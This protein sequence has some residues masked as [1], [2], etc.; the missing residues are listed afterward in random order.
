MRSGLNGN[1]MQISLIR[2]IS[3]AGI[4]IFASVLANAVPASAAYIESSLV[5]NGVFLN[6]RSMS[7]TQ[8]QTFL[9][10]KKSYLAT[11]QTFSGRDNATVPASQIIYEA[12]VDYGINPQVILA[13]LQ[14]EQSLVTDPQPASS[15]LT[16]AMGY[17]C[18][19][20]GSCS[21]PGFYKQVDNG[22]WQLRLNFERANGNNSW[23]NANI[24]YACANASRYYST[25]LY[26]NRSV[27][28]IDDGG[29][30]YKT[31]TI[32]N[33]ATASL[34]CY[35]PHA[36][37][38][39]SS[40]YYSGSYNFTAS[41]DS[42]GWSL[43][44]QAYSAQFVSQSAFPQLDPGQTTT[45]YFQYK[46][47][48]G[49]AWYDDS[50]IATSPIG[51]GAYPIHLATSR[52]L[53]RSSKFYGIG[54]ANA[55]RPAV[56]FAAVYEADGVTLASNQH[57]A[58][59]GQIVKFS[60]SMTAPS[61]LAPGTYQEN[62]MPVAEG[63]PNGAFND[64]GTYLDV[65]VNRKPSLSWMSQS[66]FPTVNASRSSKAYL[67]LTNNGNVDLYDDTSIP[68][69]PAGNY[70]VHLATS[71]PINS[72]SDFGASWPSSNRPALNFTAVLNSD[73]SPAS[74]QHVV[75]PHQRIR[76]EFDLTVP[77]GYTAAT[78]RQCFQPVLEGAV[79][80][81]FPNLGIYLDV[82]V[83]ANPVIAY[84]SPIPRRDITSGEPLTISFSIKNN[85][86][87][88]IPTG[89]KLKTDASQFQ[90]KSWMNNTTILT[91]PTDIA[92]GATQAFNVTLLAPIL[93]DIT[94]L[95]PA[96][97]F[98]TPAD[99]PIDGSSSTMEIKVWPQIFS[100]AYSGQSPYPTLSYTDT[101]NSFFKY[102]NVGNKPWYDDT[103]LAYAASRDP[104]PVHLATSVPINRGSGFALNWP[105]SN[106]P[107]L[108]F[109]AVYESDGQTLATDQHIVRPGQI[110]QFSF[111]QRPQSWVQAGI[112]REYFQPVLE[113]T[114]DGTFNTVG[115]YLDVQVR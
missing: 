89:S 7:Q 75:R 6:S 83:S 98:T 11:Y 54:W 1:V 56:N 53:N 47:T 43:R 15:Q 39:S 46:N 18:P 36:Y 105:T 103:S 28:F 114:V 45:V 29:V 48:G 16:Y 99:Q 55:A 60:F 20:G 79:S 51:S 108:T 37:P 81:Y 8:I 66:A 71:C 59:P 74:N 94:T 113:G 67:E 49:V 24:T 93:P 40:Y 90:D 96:F 95:R 101:D 62:F 82:T 115:T 109:T 65:T 31:F 104:L 92:A 14:K 13:T 91:T 86:N 73:G 22:T 4:A 64:P 21:Y 63:T 52:P 2:V 17:G 41:F 30:T 58:L 19:D 76:Y 111:Q 106:R 70:P 85:G 88:V 10:G 12:A 35:T 57:V 32:L 102:K 68:T 69:A 34:Y 100:A 42:W 78:Y 61:D 97:S 110:A 26:P 3:Y 112:Y 5:D 72:A 33:T 87:A 77:A 44:D 107:N 38:G 9:E 25:G 84:G 50:S 80:G 23:W 27:N